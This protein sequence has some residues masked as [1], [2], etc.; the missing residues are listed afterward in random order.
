MRHGRVI[1]ID[2]NPAALGGICR[3][4]ESEAETVL[5][6]ADEI[7][8]R[9]ALGS[10]APDLVLA[11]LSFPLSANAGIVR[12]IKDRFPDVK[13]IVLSI[14]DERSVVDGVMASG[15]EGFVL[16]RR[17]VIDLIPAIRE[18]LGGGRYVSSDVDEGS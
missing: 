12:E 3:L 4:L 17:A 10:Y 15:A 16:K 8:L 7:S 1:L 13:V 11:D 14:H 18:V 6:V 2:K 9:D 5:M